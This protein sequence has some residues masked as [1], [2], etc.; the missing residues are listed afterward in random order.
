[1]VVRLWQ[2]DERIYQQGR[3]VGGYR[4]T[5]PDALDRLRRAGWP[6]YSE[7]QFAAAVDT[8]RRTIGLGTVARVAYARHDTSIADV[9]ALAALA[10]LLLVLAPAG[11]LP[12]PRLRRLPRRPSGTE[13]ADAP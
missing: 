10:P 12:L 11:R 5:E 6:A 4:A 9:M 13:T 2:P 7:G 8:V 3:P 1:M